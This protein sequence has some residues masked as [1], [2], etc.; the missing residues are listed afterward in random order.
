MSSDNWRVVYYPNG[1]FW[2]IWNNLD[3]DWIEYKTKE[4]A[5]HA[6]KMLRKKK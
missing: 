5:E 3:T 1:E 4:A 6:I 2:M